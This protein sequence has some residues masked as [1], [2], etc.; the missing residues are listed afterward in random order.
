MGIIRNVYAYEKKLRT[1]ESS[2]AFASRGP[3]IR[4]FFKFYGF[5]WHISEAFGRFV[6]EH[7]VVD[8]LARRRRANPGANHSI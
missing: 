1:N 8:E 4:R 3:V 6:I 5:L 7:E 2:T